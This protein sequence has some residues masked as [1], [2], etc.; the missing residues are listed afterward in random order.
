MKVSNGISGDSSPAASPLDLRVMSFNVRCGSAPDG[1]NSWEKR[2][3]LLLERVR[4]FDPDLLGT[5]ETEDEPGAFLRAQLPEYSAFGVGRDDGKAKGESVTLFY[6]VERF[7]KLAG[8]HFWYGEHP[9]TPGLMAWDATFPRMLTWVTLRDRRSERKLLWLNTHWDNSGANSR[10]ESAK[11]LRRWVTAHGEGLP[12]IVSADFN[13]TELSPEHRH[14]LGEADTRPRLT[15]V[16]RQIHPRREPD[17]A[18]FHGFGGGR[19]GLRIDRIL[20]SP[21]FV[22]VAADIDRTSRDGRYPSDHF[23]VTAT[24]RWR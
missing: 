1:E 11:Q 24:L 9:E 20:C 16:Y 2:R 7:E 14:L 19:Q 4:R 15:D 23:P 3:D 17:E 12:L 5:Q 18:T 6:R 10:L 22:P 8:G 21:A 13:S